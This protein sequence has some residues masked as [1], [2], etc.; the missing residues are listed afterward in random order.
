MTTSMQID[1]WIEL[2]EEADRDTTGPHRPD[3]EHPD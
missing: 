2:L 1:A 3:D